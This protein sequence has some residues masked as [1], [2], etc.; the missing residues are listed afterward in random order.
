VSLRDVFKSV[1]NALQESDIP[2]MVTGSIASSVHGIPRATQDIDVVIDPTREQLL[3]LLKRFS[4]PDYDADQD[5]VIDA[6]HRRSMFSVIDR[7]GIWKIDFIVRKIRPFSKKEFDR[8][9]EI[10]IFDMPV[11]A[12]T[13]E[14]VL[15]AKLEWAQLGESERQIRDAAGIIE[16]QGEKLDTQYVERWAA[17]LDIEDQLRAARQKAG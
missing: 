11:Y 16:I 15:L 4:E 8:R 17:A 6:F 3:A 14:D 9:Q 13:P 2:Y 10:E 12:A 5:D 1:R 7:R